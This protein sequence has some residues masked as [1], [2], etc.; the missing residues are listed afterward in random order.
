MTKRELSQIYY[1][2]REVEMWQRELQRLKQQSLIKSY[3]F[4]DTPKEKGTTDNVGNLAAIIADIE[5]IINGKLAE[6]QLQRKKI[7]EYINSIDDS[8]IRQIIFYRHISCMTWEQV[9][10]Y[11]GGNNTEENIRKIY[12]RFFKKIKTCHKCHN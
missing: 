1:L 3:R 6:I 2:N 10:A 4:S 5:T 11:V 12:S 9:A 7:I 8:L